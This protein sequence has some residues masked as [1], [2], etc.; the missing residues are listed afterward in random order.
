[1]TD[2]EKTGIQGW[3]TELKGDGSEGVM[4]GLKHRK[5]VW[6]IKRGDEG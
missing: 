4:A 2:E 5:E 3:G 6:E 1:L